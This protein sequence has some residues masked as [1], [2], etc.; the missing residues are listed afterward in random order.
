[1]K[2]I[3]YRG[4]MY[5]SLSACC[6]ALDISYDSVLTYKKRTGCTTEDAID[7]FAQDKEQGKVKYIV[8]AITYKEIEYPHLNACCKALGICNSS[9]RDYRRRSGCT[10][11]EAVDYFVQRKEQGKTRNVEAV[12]YKG[13]QYHSL[14]A[15]CKALGINSRSVRTYRTRTGCTTEEAI[16]HYV[17]R[18]E[19]E[20]IRRVEAITYHGIEYHSL[21]ACCKALG[22]NNDSVRMYCRRTGCITEEAI[23]HF[24]QRKEQGKIRRVE[25]ITYHGIEYPSL[26][27]CCEVL[28]INYGSV[29]IYRTRTGCTTEE[30]IDHHVQIKEQGKARNVET[31]TYKGAKYRSLKTCC[32]VLG[33]NPSSIYHYRKRTG[34][35]IEEAIDYLLQPRNIKFAYNHRVTGEPYYECRCPKCQRYLFVSQSMLE[36]FTHSED[37]CKRQ[38]NPYKK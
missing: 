24:V 22:I 34:C 21:P 3:E 25:A 20:K 5:P 9:V 17:Q 23:G 8:E 7:H 37:F 18:K 19:Q 13:T 26:K 33:I 38:E 10:T 30:A 31:V 32:K 35:T 1:M 16:D 12:T 11:E 4:I 36:D 14:S 28:E 2:Q 15:C 27:A 29:R 6:K